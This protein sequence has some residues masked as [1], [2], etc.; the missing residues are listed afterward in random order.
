M[1]VG[2][3]FVSTESNF[4]IDLGGCSV[5]VVTLTGGSG[6]MNADRPFGIGKQEMVTAVLLRVPRQYKDAKVVK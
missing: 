1:T 2:G 4:G 5:H 3:A 6:G